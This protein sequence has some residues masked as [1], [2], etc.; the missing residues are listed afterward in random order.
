M[1]THTFLA[2]VRL[3]D[4]NRLKLR[5]DDVPDD[6]ETVRQL[7]ADE[8]AEAGT[9]AQCIVIRTDSVRQPSKAAA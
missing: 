4:G 8:L 6:I 3:K 5:V 7:I 9:P 1:S 2:A